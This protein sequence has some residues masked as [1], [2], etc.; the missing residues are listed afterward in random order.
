MRRSRRRWPRSRRRS[1]GRTSTPTSGRHHLPRVSP[2]ARSIAGRLPRL[3]RR[4]RTA[5]VP[6]WPARRRDRSPGAARRARAPSRRRRLLAP[7]ARNCG[8]PA[9]RRP[10]RPAPPP[11]TR[12]SQR[13]G[14]RAG[15]PS[16]RRRSCTGHQRAAEAGD[17][18]QGRAR[19]WAGG[20]SCGRRRR[21]ADLRQR[22]ARTDR[23]RRGSPEWPS[24]PSPPADG[25][26]AK[27]RSNSARM[28][29]AAAASAVAA[30]LSST[31]LTLD[32]GGRQLGPAQRGQGVAVEA[33][34]EQQ[35]ARRVLALQERQRQPQLAPRHLAL[36]RRAAPAGPCAAAASRTPGRGR[37]RP[38]R[39]RWRR[40]GRPR[41]RGT[42]PAGSARRRSA[43]PDP[44]ARRIPAR[45]RRAG[46]CG[47]AAPPAAAAPRDRSPTPDGSACNSPSA[48]EKRS[49]C[50]D[51]I[52]GA[53]S[54]ARRR[55][56]A[57]DGGRRPGLRLRRPAR[58]RSPARASDWIRS[59]AR[60][61]TSIQV[62][63]SPGSRARR[64]G[65]RQ[66]DPAARLTG[67]AVPHI[68]ERQPHRDRRLDLV[69]RVAALVVEGAVGVAQVKVLRQPAQVLGVPQEQ[70]A[71]RRQRAA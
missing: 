57:S 58:R 62:A 7:S 9:R 24:R 68:V 33:A 27:P 46:R 8:P 43:R 22:A 2:L 23:R 48:S 26:R 63:G 32:P 34:A 11:A 6:T 15:Y 54:G 13:A 4:W 14:A 3:P 19:C 50:S 51:S 37:P 64:A 17:A 25:A 41:P 60:R 5:R 45:R 59:V 31:V 47:S 69:A 30:P 12:T 20:R 10:G 67:G 56:P 70:V 42:A 21:P 1:S 18:Q 29:A 35:Q 53:R 40:R 16:S 55:G 71:A 65:H 61:M 39:G 66:R 52:T 36:S 38:D 28:R 44:A 49:R